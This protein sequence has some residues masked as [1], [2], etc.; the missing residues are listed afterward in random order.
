[1]SN[2]E[3]DEVCANCGK[4]AVDDVKLKICTACKLVKYCSVEC[5]RNHRPQHKK[6]CKKR[7]AQ[8]RDNLLF[9]QPDGTHLGECPLCCLPQPIDGGRDDMNNSMIYSCCCKRICRGCSYANYLR[10]KEQ[11]LEQKCPYCREELPLTKED[12]VHQNYMKRA[13]ANDP[14]AL[15][16]LGNR[17]DREGN[18]EGAVEYWKKAAALG[19]I[20]SHQN[21]SLMYH[22]GQGVERDEKKKIY[23]AEEAAIGGHPRARNNLS[24]IEQNRGRHDR[25]MQHLIIAAKQGFDDGLEAVKKGFSYGIVSKEDFEAALRGH[26]AAVDATKSEQREKA[27]DFYKRRARGFY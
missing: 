14:V 7:A 15:C 25:A 22:E 2:T 24:V 1:M 17:C 18:F 19:D 6:V 9:T 16:E 23:H 21:L 3:G 5:Q 12:E 4:T 26:Q 8:L 20:E 11:G 13:K 10:E 27:Y